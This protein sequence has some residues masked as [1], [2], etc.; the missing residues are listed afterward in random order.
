MTDKSNEKAVEKFLKSK[1]LDATLK[2][3]KRTED[4]IE[5]EKTYQLWSYLELNADLKSRVQRYVGLVGEDVAEF[6]FKN[7][8][9]L[10]PIAC[11]LE[12]IDFLRKHKEKE[13]LKEKKELLKAVEEEFKDKK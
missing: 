10:D 5:R 13:E 8:D 2:K 1:K 3:L 12:Y 7:R 6:Y 4:E 9:I 11:G